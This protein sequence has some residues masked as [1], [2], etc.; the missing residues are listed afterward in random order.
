[1]L[2]CIN[3]WIWKY[4]VLDTLVYRWLQCILPIILYNC[5]FFHFSSSWTWHNIPSNL[6]YCTY[7]PH[8]YMFSLHLLTGHTLMM[9][10]GR[11]ALKEK[12]QQTSYFNSSRR[13]CIGMYACE[14]T[15]RSSNSDTTAFHRVT[16][17][18][19]A[20]VHY[21]CLKCWRSTLRPQCFY[22]PFVQC[23][24]CPKK[25]TILS[26]SATTVRECLRE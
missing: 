26:I 13:E 24:L 25:T 17:S 23:L 15:F 11:H 9:K 20:R 16:A 3:K 12:K 10:N 7:L 8:E 19:P 6:N 18:V 21:E 14:T 2:A 5:G 22:D 1:M 4:C